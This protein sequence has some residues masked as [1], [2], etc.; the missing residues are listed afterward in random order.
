M[1]GLV[2]CAGGVGG[3]LLAS[4]L[5]FAKQWLGSDQAGF[6]IFAA[7]ALVAL[8]ALTAVKGRWR[9]T[10]ITAAQGVRI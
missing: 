5:G 7:L 2:G 4:S 9:S 6:L 3:F 10:W 1:T 8:A